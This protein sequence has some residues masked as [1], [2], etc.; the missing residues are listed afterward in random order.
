MSLSSE[1]RVTCA[2]EALFLL[3]ALA[4]SVDSL[5]QPSIKRHVLRHSILQAELP[6]LT[7]FKQ[8]LENIGTVA[9][10]SL[11]RAWTAQRMIYC[12]LWPQ[13]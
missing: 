10:D 6:Y 7:G 3:T 1:Q 5:P 2:F 4:F 12:Y 13:R 11:L 9:S 8:R